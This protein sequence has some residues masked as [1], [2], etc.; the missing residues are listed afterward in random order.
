MK[1]DPVYA[2]KLAYYCTLSDKP[3]YS[4]ERRPTI[5]AG[6]PHLENET[7]DGEAVT[8]SAYL[9]SIIATVRMVRS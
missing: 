4:L 5:G 6:G 7:W 3:R 1:L 8:G 2:N 9:I